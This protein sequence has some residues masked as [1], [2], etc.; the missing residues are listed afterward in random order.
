MARRSRLSRNFQRKSRNTLILSILGIA[1]VLFLLFRYGLP[2][3]SDASFLFGR[4]TSKPNQIDKKNSEDEEFVPV[5]N[6]DSLPKATNNQTVTVTGTSLSGLFIDLYL[7]GDKEDTE[8]V[9]ENG[10]FE[11]SL[12]LSE[13]E[14]IIK[15]RAR[16][17]N[18]ESEFSNSVIVIY[19]KGGPELSIESP[20]EGVEIKGANPIEVKGK[21]DSD[22]S[23][24]VND[25]QAITNSEGNWSYYLTL[26]GGDNEIKVV[27]TDLAGNKTEKI[28]HVNYSQ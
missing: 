9:D 10:E 2:L 16:K 21:T 23:V 25:F 17:E 8:G 24:L 5:P 7:N 27:A 1:A 3:I 22:S 26:K 11:F 28:I 18:E 19:K 4:I 13:G 6:I 12:D 20:G 15:V 14:N